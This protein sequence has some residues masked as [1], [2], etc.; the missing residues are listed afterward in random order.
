MGNAEYDR[1]YLLRRQAE[2]EQQIENARAVRRRLRSPRDD[3]RI[4]SADELIKGLESDLAS[5]EYCI[6]QDKKH[7]RYK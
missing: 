3:R 2:L 1:R 5:I 6:R 4:G 7:G